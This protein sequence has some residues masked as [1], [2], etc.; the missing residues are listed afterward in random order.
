M[1]LDNYAVYGKEH[2]KYNHAEDA[3]NSIP[4]EFFP[5]NDLCGGIFSGGGSSF[6]GKV[7]NDVVEFFTGYSLYEDVLETEDVRE[8]FVALNGVTEDR[9]NNEFSP[10]NDWG[11]TYGEVQQLAEWFHIVAE[12]GGS[13]ISWY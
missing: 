3:I 4:N 12:E 10:H 2:H 6:R 8:I 11:I 9:F 13:V 7:Y 5:Q 1:G